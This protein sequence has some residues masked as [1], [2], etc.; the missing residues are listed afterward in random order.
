MEGD[1]PPPHPL[2]RWGE[3][4]RERHAEGSTRC[5]E[6]LPREIRDEELALLVVG[7]TAGGPHQLL[8]VG[9]DDGEAVE[10]VVVGDALLAAGLGVHEVELI[11]LVPVSAGGV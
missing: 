1:M 4:T 3:G 5:R 8:A 9:A 10:A 2:P 11:I 6:R 7:A